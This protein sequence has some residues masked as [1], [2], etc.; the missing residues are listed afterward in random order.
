[1]TRAKADKKYSENIIL[2]AGYQSKGTLGR[3]PLDGVKEV[4]LFGEDIAVNAEIA[5]LHGT[6][7][8]ADQKGLLNWVEAFEKKPEAIFVNHG[9]TEACEAFQALLQKKGYV[10]VAPFSN[11]EFDLISGKFLAFPEGRPIAKRGTEEGRLR[12]ADRG[13]TAP[14]SRGAELQGTSEPRSDPLHC[15]D[16]SAY[17]PVGEIK[18]NI[19]MPVARILRKNTAYWEES[20]QLLPFFCEVYVDKAKFL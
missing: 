17:R 6:S 2:I 10:A 12:R 4:R 15:A 9:D 18:A 5:V 1:M 8:H 11:A 13:G 14:A 20:A 19:I 7:G 3:A 16:P